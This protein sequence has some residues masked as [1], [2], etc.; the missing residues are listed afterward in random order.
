MRFDL[1]RPCGN[2]PFRTDVRPYIDA[3]RVRE[4][5]GGGEKR[6]WWPAVSFPCHKTIDYDVEDG[7]RPNIGPNAQQCAGVMIILTRDKRPNDAMQLGERLCGFDASKLD[8]TS[9]VYESAAAAIAAHEK[10]D[11]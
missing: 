2:C 1:T 6:A 7:E 5:L 9:P 4:I 10:E 11:S 8:M 3:R